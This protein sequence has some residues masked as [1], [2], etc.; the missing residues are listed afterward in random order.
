L[1]RAV[2]GDAGEWG[3]SEELLAAAVDR[4]GHVGY[5]L[6]RAHFKGSSEPPPPIP[7]PGRPA[8]DPAGL[9]DGGDFE[10]LSAAQARALLDEYG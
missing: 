9:D 5:L 7:R 10:Q 1:A 2:Y 6:H 8:T 4:L 3:A